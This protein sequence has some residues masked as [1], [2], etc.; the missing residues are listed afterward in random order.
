MFQQSV[1]FPRKVVIFHCIVYI[2]CNCGFVVFQISFTYGLRKVSL[3][4]LPAVY[5]K[6][7][8]YVSNNVSDNIEEN[9]CA[10]YLT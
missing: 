2:S 9:E 5:R 10:K 8:S 3:R 6:L 4:I 7:L 1:G